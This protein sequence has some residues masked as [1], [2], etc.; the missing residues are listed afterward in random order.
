[1]AD[2]FTTSIKSLTLPEL[3]QLY[4][5]RIPENIRLEYKS[6]VLDNKDLAKTISSFANT[7]GG[8]L[9]IGILTDKRGN[10]VAMEGVDS[11]SGYAQTVIAAAYA[12]IYPPVIPIVSDPIALDNG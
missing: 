1:M 3:T 12:Q 8:Y 4:T 9:V 2:F 11:V 5:D 10:P 7:Y 6:Q